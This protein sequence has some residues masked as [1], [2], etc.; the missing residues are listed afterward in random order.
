MARPSRAHVRRLPLLI[1]VIQ[2]T[3]G[4]YVRQSALAAAVSPSSLS[5]EALRLSDVTGDEPVLASL[6][7]LLVTQLK[8]P[9]R[10]SCAAA[11]ARGRR[12]P[13][14]LLLSCFAPGGCQ[15]LRESFV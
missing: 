10:G 2:A 11:C 7:R 12:S 5:W 8:V 4:S 1:H 3:E 9:T 14:P 13:A 15:P 6:R